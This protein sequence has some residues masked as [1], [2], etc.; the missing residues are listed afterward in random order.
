[1]KGGE[2]TDFA[3][4]SVAMREIRALTHAQTLIDNAAPV[5]SPHM[6]AG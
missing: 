5:D 6:A 2:Q 1:L 3:M 4:M